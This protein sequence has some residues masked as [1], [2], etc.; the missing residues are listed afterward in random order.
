MRSKKK[1]DC[2]FEMHTAQLVYNALLKECYRTTL[3]ILWFT[4]N[5]AVGAARGCSHIP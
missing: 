1:S 3:D 5:S 2:A 4:L